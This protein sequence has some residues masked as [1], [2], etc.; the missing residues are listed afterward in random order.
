[1]NDITQPGVAMASDSMPIPGDITW[2]T[3]YEKLPN[4][5]PC[6]AGAHA[7]S[8]KIGREKRIS[9][10]QTLSQLSYVTAKHLADIGLESMKERGRMQEGRVADVVVFDPVTVKDNATYARGALPSTGIP[11]VIVN[12][13]QVVRDSEVLKDVNPG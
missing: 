5:H 9:L 10:M 8:L 2:D 6:T 3:P 1:M 13:V 4:T 11:H 7:A 12:G